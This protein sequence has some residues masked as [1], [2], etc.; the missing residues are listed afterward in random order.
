[1][2]MQN[3]QPVEVDRI[4]IVGPIVRKFGGGVNDGPAPGISERDGVRLREQGVDLVEGE[5]GGTGERDQPGEFS[6]AVMC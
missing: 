5:Y 1:M 4:G 2:D 3:E 6:D